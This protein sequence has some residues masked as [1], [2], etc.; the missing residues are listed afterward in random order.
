MVRG[1]CRSQT[2]SPVH[3][4]GQITAT[5]AW[6]LPCTHGFKIT[7]FHPHRPDVPVSS[8]LSH[9]H[10]AGLA[11][12]IV[13]QILAAAVNV[14]FHFQ[15]CVPGSLFLFFAVSSSTGLPTSRQPND[16][17]KALSSPWALGDRGRRRGRKRGRGGGRGGPP[18][19]RRPCIF[20]T[21]FG[22]GLLGSR[23]VAAELWYE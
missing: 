21:A 2:E 18:W 22:Q 3:L 10:Y 9:Q 5:P 20:P 1:R 14:P 23:F 8:L 13:V 16:L 6:T 19:D 11:Y 17:H 15:P 12:S 7:V 4:N